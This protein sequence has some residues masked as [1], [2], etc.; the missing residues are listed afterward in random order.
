MK[1]KNKLSQ[2]EL[3]GIYESIKKKFP[4]PPADKSDIMIEADS[5]KARDIYE[6]AYKFS[7]DNDKNNLLETCKLLLSNYPDSKEAK[8][9]IKRFNLSQADV[10]VWI[11]AGTAKKKDLKKPEVNLGGWGKLAN[12]FNP[13]M[14]GGLIFLGPPGWIL[15]W[16]HSIAC[17]KMRAKA[18]DLADQ[19]NALAKDGRNAEALLYLQVIEEN[20][21]PEWRP[22]QIST[23]QKTDGSQ[24]IST[25]NA[26]IN[27]LK[28]S[29]DID[30]IIKALKDVNGHTRLDVVRVLGQMRD[31]RSV[32][33]LIEALTDKEDYV[34]WSAAEALGVIGNSMAI[35]P[36][37]RTL[38][39]QHPLV[40][41]DAAKALSQFDDPRAV[42]AV[43]EYKKRK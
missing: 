12:F 37:I 11:Q 26:N 20:F 30:G 35:G 21:R 3:D 4:A 23:I 7:A 39:D 8:W 17:D 13:L 19:V 25:L 34:R 33:P 2:S 38:N 15:M 27:E 22:K 41:K 28:D 18:Q 24:I 16:L 5:L 31:A 40:R 10:T 43:E 1:K 6:K 9:A 36:L 29:G 14:I 42:A 32:E